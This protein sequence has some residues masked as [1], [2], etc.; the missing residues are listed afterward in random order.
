MFGDVPDEQQ[1]HVIVFE[2]HLNFCKREL[3]VSKG[4][5]ILVSI[6][7][8]TISQSAAFSYEQAKKDRNHADMAYWA[9]S[10]ENW[11]EHIEMWQLELDYA[12]YGNIAIC[13]GLIIFQLLDGT[14]L[15]SRD[16][17]L[18]FAD[19]QSFDCHCE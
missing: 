15:D 5:F 19:E 8:L 3:E 9:E 2:R 17:L 10:M 14:S 13:G 4:K 11:S 12:H 16:A 6:F 18:H 7:P 1:L